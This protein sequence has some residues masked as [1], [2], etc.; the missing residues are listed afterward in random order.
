[1]T[2]YT[3]LTI[4][5]VNKMMWKDLADNADVDLIV[6]NTHKTAKRVLRRWEDVTIADLKALTRHEYYMTLA[7]VEKRYFQLMDK[8]DQ[9]TAKVDAV[10]DAENATENIKTRRLNDL[11]RIS[12]EYKAFET[13]WEMVVTKGPRF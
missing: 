4:D 9:L 1:M 12:A 8:K 3:E 7:Y 13:F 6:H 2:I 11:V 10:I 5:N